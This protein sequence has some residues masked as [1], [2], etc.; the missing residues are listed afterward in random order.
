MKKIIPLVLMFLSFCLRADDPSGWET[1]KS[2]MYSIEYRVSQLESLLSSYTDGMTAYDILVELETIE[3]ICSSMNNM[4]LNISDSFESQ[5]QVLTQMK[6]FMDDMKGSLV[7]VSSYMIQLHA[8]V[9]NLETTLITEFTELKNHI[10]GLGEEITDRLDN[11]ISLLESINSGIGSLGS[12]NDE[13]KGLLSNQNQSLDNLL[14]KLDDIVVNLGQISVNISSNPWVGSGGS[15]SNSVNLANISANLQKIITPYYD[16]AQNWYNSPMRF[17]TSAYYYLDK[18]NSLQTEYRTT[19]GESDFFRTCIRWLQRNDSNVGRLN[20]GLMVLTRY[21][22]TNGVD[23]AQAKCDIQNTLNEGRA[24]LESLKSLSDSLTSPF[25]GKDA[26]LLHCRKSSILSVFKNVSSCP[27]SLYLGE[28][29][30]F[31]IFGFECPQQVF[32]V[33]ISDW[34]GFFDFMR[35]CSIV[36]LYCFLTGVIVLVLWVLIRVIRYVGSMVAIAFGSQNAN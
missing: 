25:D 31:E 22:Q 3:S 12:S 10:T 30:S 4:L 32:V 6:L 19:V 5:Y 11:V 26:S 2:Q 16:W 36:F 17:S 7:D 27:S 15:S 20:T 8:D 9:G 28:I 33:N 1:F 14:A 23:T 21:L 35:S 24:T 34:Q 29:S 18:N 13:V